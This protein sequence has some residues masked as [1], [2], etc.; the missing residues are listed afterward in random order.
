MAFFNE[1]PH[2]RT[3]DSDL[4]WLIGEMKKLLVEWGSVEEAWN[5]FLEKFQPSIDETV[6]KILTEWKDDGTLTNLLL[7]LTDSLPFVSVKDYGA[8]GDGITND[9]ESF[10]K[11]IN[12]SK[13]LFVPNGTYLLDSL[14]LPENII[15]FGE[16][17][18][19]VLKQ[20]G[21][22][23]ENFIVMNNGNTIKHLTIDGNGVGKNKEIASVYAIGK[24]N[25]KIIDCLIKNGYQ[26]NIYQNSCKN[27][28]IKDCELSSCVNGC[29]C[30]VASQEEGMVLIDNCFSH[31]NA[32]DGFILSVPGGIIQNC[33]SVKNGLTLEAGACGVFVTEYADNG[34]IANN[35][36]DG[37]GYAGIE[38]SGNAENLRIINNI[39]RNNAED[40]IEIRQNLKCFVLGNFL[41]N[42][43]STQ[44][45]G[46]ISYSITAQDCFSVISNNIIDCNEKSEFGIYAP[47]ANKCLGDNIV[48]N[49]TGEKIN[50]SQ[51]GNLSVAEGNNYKFIK[52]YYFRFTDNRFANIIN[53]GDS[54]RIQIAGNQPF[55]FVSTSGGSEKVYGEHILPIKEITEPVNGNIYVD[56]TGLH[57]YYNG[58]KAINFA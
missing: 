56:G 25:I 39:V 37:N 5:R 45:G 36:C 1:F 44:F 12:T 30:T 10:N 6:L 58:W 57:I 48:F 41:Y 21:N 13:W 16:S 19:A 11:A 50:A 2:T 43:N 24:N 52:R 51:S 22:V 34:I 38:V 18:N 27:S 9:T 7:S 53:S 54:N 42:N 40:G 29:S 8:S 14:E 49:S 46:Q 15:I 47:N 26:W 4:G 32:L 55:E 35:I 23:A 3:Y 33:K 17:R 31:N 28:V 20:N